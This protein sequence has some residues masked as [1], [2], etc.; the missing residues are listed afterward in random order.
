M[1]ALH[2]L[3]AHDQ[4]DDELVILEELSSEEEDGTGAVKFIGLV[5]ESNAELVSTYAWENDI[6]WGDDI[7]EEMQARGTVDLGS[8]RGRPEPLVMPQTPKNQT[9]GLPHP[10]M[11]RLEGVPGATQ[12][13]VEA[14][15]APVKG[16][17]SATLSAKLRLEPWLT[18]SEEWLSEVVPQTSMVSNGRQLPGRHARHVV[19]ALSGRSVGITMQMNLSMEPGSAPLILDLNDPGMVFMSE[20]AD[21]EVLRSAA[22]IVR[23]APPR[24]TPAAGQPMNPDDEV[25]SPEP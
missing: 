17:M 24:I 1:L 5:P 8:Y 14:A 6:I 12:S 9:R 19:D 15:A 16:G 25:C 23:G 22:A 13:L 18:A 21:G 10:Q 4:R 3:L 2:E 20:E 11:L 7:E